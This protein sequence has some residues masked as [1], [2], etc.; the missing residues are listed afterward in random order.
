M[1]IASGVQQFA[2][3]I[4]ITAVF[5][6]TLFVAQSASAATLFSDYFSTGNLSQWTQVD[7]AGT[8]GGWLTSVTQSVTP[9]SAH[10]IGS[11]GAAGKVMRKQ[12]S[13]EGYTALSLSFNYKTSSFDYDTKKKDVDRVFVEYSTDG[14]T[15]KLLKDV[16]TKTAALDAKVLGSENEDTGWKKSVSTVPAN[17]NFQ[18]RL[19]AVLSDSGD[20]FWADAVILSGTPMENTLDRCSDSIDNDVD[21]NI[22]INDG[23]C[24]DF[25]TKLDVV[26]SGDGQGVVTSSPAGI[27]CGLDCA[28]E[29][30]SSVVVTLKAVAARGSAFLGWSNDCAG[31]GDCEVTMEDDRAVTATFGALAAYTLTVSA[32][33]PTQ[34]AVTS[35][36]PG[37]NCGTDC[38]EI[39]FAGETISLKATPAFGFEFDTWSDA[40][41]GTNQSCDLTI[42]GNTHATANFKPRTAGI[43]GNGTIE[44]NE[45]CDQG[46]G[47]TMNG[48]GCSATCMIE[49]PFTC[50][51]EPSQCFIDFEPVCT[52]YVCI[53]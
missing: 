21:G 3:K 28:H 24:E 52:G 13:T 12:V 33:L 44:W 9:Y 30:L 22:D 23:E 11:T 43:C 32:N 10:A 47:N 51:G 17:A 35:V 25:Y 14:V 2:A 38:A 15:W 48:D 5:F 20:R 40:C 31:L 26:K 49:A 1:H 39:L 53:F 7:N 46:G 37:I 50:T 29:Y 8:T 16:N 6:G 34:G 42:T 36:F 41:S 27:N 45:Q 4:G 19:R 18:F